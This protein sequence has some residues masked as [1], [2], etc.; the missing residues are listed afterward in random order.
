MILFYIIQSYYL[1]FLLDLMKALPMVNYYWPLRLRPCAKVFISVVAME[2]VPYLTLYNLFWLSVSSPHSVLLAKEE[3]WMI[4]ICKLGGEGSK[5]NTVAHWLL[6]YG[7][8]CPRPLMFCQ[9]SYLFIFATKG[10][11]KKI[12]RFPES[13][14]DQLQNRLAVLL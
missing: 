2:T 3:A 4:Q 10:K 13:G 1:T 12:S 9:C 5:E 7:V 14:W 8:T 11:K 6:S